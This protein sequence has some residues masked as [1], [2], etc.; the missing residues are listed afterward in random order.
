[1]NA[2]VLTAAT[3]KLSVALVSY[4]HAPYIAQALESVLK[5][6]TE[7]PFEIVIGEDCSTDG[8]REMVKDYGSRYPELITLLLHPHNLG[9]GGDGNFL[10]VLGACRG[11]YVAL[12]DGDDYWTHD[13][14]LQ[15][16][17]DYLDSHP[18]LAG[19]FHNA[20][21]VDREGA[22]IK[23]EHYD[24]PLRREHRYKSRFSQADCLT[25]LRSAYPTCSLTFRRSA[26]RHMP[27]WFLASPSDF[28]L[29]ILLTDH[30]E[31]AYLPRSYGAYRIHDS[32]IW[33]GRPLIDNYLEIF[34]RLMILLRAPE[35][36]SK[37][38]SA[39]FREMRDYALRINY[40]SRVEERILDLSYLRNSFRYVC[41]R[42]ST[43]RLIFGQL[44]RRLP[45]G[46]ARMIGVSWH[47][48]G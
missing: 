5:Q 11:T 12:L 19:C 36:R 18:E 24:E 39:L 45:A 34:R 1:M 23:S 35:L 14:K 32:G 7:F 28:A 20:I 48:R 26:I 37:H 30:G 3:P 25:M 38:E 41:D 31:L 13:R 16:Q 47:G 40:L 4:N 46:I 43:Y 6:R 2:S 9:C 33:Q 27:D 10:E 15:E 8:T 21:V 17:V 22:T 42:R 29:D 44:L